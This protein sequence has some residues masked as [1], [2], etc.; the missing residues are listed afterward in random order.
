[1][2]KN[3]ERKI[4]FCKSEY[5]NL[6]SW[7]LQ[8]C[9]EEKAIN[10][11]YVPWQGNICFNVSDFCYIKSAIFNKSNDKNINENE[12]EQ[13]E[14]DDYADAILQPVVPIF[15]KHHDRNWE[16]YNVS[17]SLFGTDRIIEKFRLRI[18]VREYESL[19]VHVNFR[20]TDSFM[21]TTDDEI[22]VEVTTSKEKF[23]ELVNLLKGGGDE[24][25]EIS[26][27][28]ATGFYYDWQ[29]SHYK[30]PGNIILKV[31]S[32]KKDHQI[33][34]KEASDVVVPKLGSFGELSIA[35]KRFENLPKSTENNTK[36]CLYSLEEN[37]LRRDEEIKK[38]ITPLWVICISILLILIGQFFS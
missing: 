13:V 2:D 29:P 19:Q 24:I 1:M 23:S 28:G 25:K 31:L 18:F 16:K 21:Y 20:E 7:Y 30:T 32:N 27:C 37:L 35:T 9:S 26:L 22:Q 5:K 33:I 15:L 10:K 8:E 3:I 14:S 6:Y 11:S 36:N 4:K 34:Y 17:Y 12:E 38:L